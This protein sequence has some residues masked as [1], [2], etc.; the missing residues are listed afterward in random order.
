MLLQKAVAGVGEL[1][2]F[3]VTAEALAAQTN[4]ELSFQLYYDQLV[5]A[6]TT[7]DNKRVSNNRA[8]H[9]RRRQLHMAMFGEPPSDEE[10]D[11]YNTRLG[12]PFE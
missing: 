5:S 4:V 7:F 1:A 8:A 12:G 3:K 2:A 9:R 6:A 11:G 10:E